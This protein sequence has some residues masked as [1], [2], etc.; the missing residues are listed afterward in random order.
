MRKHLSILIVAA[1]L[2]GCTV[3]SPIQKADES[4]SGFDGAIVDGDRVVLSN[5][6]NNGVRYRIFHQGATGFVPLTAIRNSA[7]KRAMD[8]CSK[9]NKTMKLLEEKSATPL[10]GWPSWPRIEYIFVCQDKPIDSISGD[11]DPY[12]KLRNLKQLLDDRTITQDEFE[13]E[14]RKI[15]Q[16]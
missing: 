1:T 4:T 14:K 6:P 15:L 10:S 12:K 8:F 5:D 11:G 9:E 2:T 16:R 7:E 13:N 3:A